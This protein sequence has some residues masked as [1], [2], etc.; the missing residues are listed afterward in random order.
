MLALYHLASGTPLSAYPQ[1]VQEA[2]GRVDPASLGKVRRVAL[3][4]THL[5]P[6]NP[7]GARGRNRGA[8]PVG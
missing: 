7:T 6:G 3:I 5:M 2:L 4:G 1:G 8:H